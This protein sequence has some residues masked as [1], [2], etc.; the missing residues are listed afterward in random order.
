VV[1]RLHGRPFRAERQPSR[2][3]ISHS[4]P[5]LAIYKRACGSSAENSDAKAR[6]SFSRSASSA[7]NGKIPAWFFPVVSSPDLRISFAL[8]LQWSRICSCY[9]RPL[10]FK[11]ET[12]KTPEVQRRTR[13]TGRTSILRGS[14]I[15]QSGDCEFHHS[16]DRTQQ[17]TTN[18]LWRNA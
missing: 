4:P 8:L 9:W 6:Q 14:K 18:H 2:L 3:R 15:G 13:A 16:N 11:G 12:S 7:G 5:R 1:C 17:T 10:L